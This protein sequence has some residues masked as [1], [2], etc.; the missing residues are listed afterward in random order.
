M[1][2]VGSEYVVRLYKRALLHNILVEEF[3]HADLPPLPPFPPS[4]PPSLPPLSFPLSLPPLLS[5]SLP[6]PSLPPAFLP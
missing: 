6:G 5:P 4:L 2:S 3:Q 1:I